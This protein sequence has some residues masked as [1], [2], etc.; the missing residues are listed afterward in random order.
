MA[1]WVGKRGGALRL[2]AA[3]AVG[4]GD[5]GVHGGDAVFY[6]VAGA[7]E[8][9]VSVGLLSLVVTALDMAGLFFILAA[10]SRQLPDIVRRRSAPQPGDPGA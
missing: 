2:A 8:P 4:A 9:S 10:C 1:G 3:R 7:D 5:P 6:G